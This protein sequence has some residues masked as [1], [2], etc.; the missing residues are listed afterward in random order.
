[1]RVGFV[2][3]GHMGLPMATRLAAHDFPLIVW[4]RTASRRPR[5]PARVAMGQRRIGEMP[6]H[7]IC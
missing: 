3:L 5:W 7:N 6:R 4:N 1:M 2:D